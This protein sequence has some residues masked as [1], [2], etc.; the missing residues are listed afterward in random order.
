[1]EVGYR[2]SIHC[3]AEC[4]YTC[5]QSHLQSRLALYTLADP[6]DLLCLKINSDLCVLRMLLTCVSV[7][8]FAIE[9]IL[10]YY[11]SHIKYEAFIYI[12]LLMSFLTTE[13]LVLIIQLFQLH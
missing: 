7:C 4:E 5:L 2:N 13:L 1:M 12:L 9:A 6:G 3:K 11:I 10:N 8:Y